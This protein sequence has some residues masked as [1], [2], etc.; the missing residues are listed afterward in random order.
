MKIAFYTLTDTN[1]LK[2][3][4]PLMRSV[5]KFF[6]EAA[7]NVISL[8]LT[9]KARKQ[10]E[11]H[12]VVIHGAPQILL[13]ESRPSDKLFLSK[14]YIDGIDADYLVHVDSDAILAGRVEALLDVPLGQV[15]VV[16]ESYLGYTVR[17]QFGKNLPSNYLLNSYNIDPSNQS[18]N[19]GIFA[20][21]KTDIKSLKREIEKLYSNETLVKNMRTDQELLAVALAK[22]NML[23]ELSEHC[24]TIDEYWDGRS[25]AVITPCDK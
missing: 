8:G 10:L 25:N 13:G 21:R 2:G 24:N 15:G 18:Y 12:G 20:G 11:Q 17:D 16:G 22:S 6:P 7:L 23:C 4:L 3:T 14:Y 5:K 1:Y 19:C 9:E